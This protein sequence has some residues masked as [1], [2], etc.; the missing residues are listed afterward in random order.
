MELC[1]SDQLMGLLG[2]L[3]SWQKGDAMRRKNQ[4]CLTPIGVRSTGYLCKGSSYK[5][6]HATGH[7]NSMVCVTLVVAA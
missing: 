6:V 4:G 1:A 5:E 3:G 2:P 7:R